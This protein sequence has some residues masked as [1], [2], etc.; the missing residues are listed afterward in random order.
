MNIEKL[1][2]M[3]LTERGGNSFRNED[4][5]IVLFQH[6]EGDK[7]LEISHTPVNYPAWNIS[8]IEMTEENLIYHIGEH[9]GE[10]A[11]KSQL[12]INKVD[13]LVYSNEQVIEDVTE[14]V[15]KLAD[16]SGFD[17]T[18]SFGLPDAV[19]DSADILGLTLTEK[20]KQ[21]IIQT[22]LNDS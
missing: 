20:L 2:E 10:W 1:L 22:I 17:P 13:G 12:N 8:L 16:S 21:E 11:G 4:G 15:F 5:S 19:T 9:L 18:E 7:Y 6:L 14:H 3:G